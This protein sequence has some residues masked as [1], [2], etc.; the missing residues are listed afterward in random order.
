[1]AAPSPDPTARRVPPAPVR[2]ACLALAVISLAAGVIGLFLPVVPTVPFILLAAWAAARGSPRLLHWL[3]THPHFGPTLTD[4]RSGRVVR[5]KAKWLAAAAMAG[6]AASML[7][8]V[9]PRW[10]VLCVIAV[11]AA[12]LAWLWQRPESLPAEATPQP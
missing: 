2:W 3:E 1:M 6:S 5:R 10:Y 4:W 8:I 12:V 7:L 11:L 9:G